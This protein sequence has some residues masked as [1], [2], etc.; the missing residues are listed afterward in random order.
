M[1]KEIRKCI[2]CKTYTLKDICPKC[3]SK[4]ITPQP[5]KYSPDDKYGSL[6]RKYKK[7]LK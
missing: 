4:T 5:A 6:R 2:K 1:K 7:C 3:N